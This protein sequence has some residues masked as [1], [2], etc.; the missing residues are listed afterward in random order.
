[1]TIEPRID[2]LEDIL[3]RWKQALGD[4][5]L[6][7]RNHVY[8]MVHFCFALHGGDA[9]A[10]E[11]IVIAGCFHDLGIWSD[12]TIDY[13]PPSAARARDYLLQHGREAWIEEVGLMID[14]HHKLRGYHD[15]RY[16]LVEVFRRADLVD[17]SLGMVKFGLPRAYIHSVKRQFP[18]AGFHKRLVQLAGGW[19]RKHPL[20]PPPFLKW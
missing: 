20:S 16:P 13:L 3:G 12:G 15:M 9:Q 8:R 10:R 4:D 18:N 1:M 19:L 14:L 6:A 7:Y 2:L 11:K 17:V 5:F